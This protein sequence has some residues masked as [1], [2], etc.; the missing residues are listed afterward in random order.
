MKIRMLLILFVMPVWA[1]AQ[2]VNFFTGSWEE[3]RAKAKAEGKM[4]L[5]DAYTYWCGPC[6]VMDKTM[7]HGNQEV[8]D[9]INTH[10]VAYKVECEHDAGVAFARKYKVNV[11]PTLLFFNSNGELLEK[12]LG[13]NS[14]QQEFLKG[15]KEMVDMD[16]TNVYAIDHKQMEMPWPDFYIKYF[17]DAND[18]TW[19]RDR[20]V[21]ANVWLDQQSDLFSETVWSVIYMYTLN[22]KYTNYFL[23]NLNEYKSRY[24]FEAADKVNNIV[25]SY[26]DKS[27]KEKNPDYFAKAESLLR[28]HSLNPEAEVFYLRIN[29]YQSLQDYASLAQLLDAQIAAK[30][31]VSL[32]LV[33]DLAWSIYEGCEDVVVLKKAVAWFEP[34]LK[35][36]DDYNAMDTY[37]ALLF[38][39]KD[40]KQ[41]E[42]WAEKAIAQGKQDGMD[43]KLT[44]ALLEQIKAAK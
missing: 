44:E 26:L 17:K 3:V 21:D 15:F 11:Y 31:E 38:K 19:K 33:N 18:S 14:D 30:E 12:H 2:D 40:Y 7:F 41:A 16:Q 42:T 24:K 29:Y 6:K 37:A 23:N 1:F 8:A 32:G 27:I 4:I 5:V 34:F 10:F 43:V 9:Y 39:T 36:M 20:S 28:A 35:D 22:D 13:Y 25:Y